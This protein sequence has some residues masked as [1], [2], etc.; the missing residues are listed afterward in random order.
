MKHRLVWLLLLCGT[1]CGNLIL[2]DRPATA[3]SATDYTLYGLALDSLFAEDSLL[4]VRDSVVA[5]RIC[6]KRENADSESEKVLALYDFDTDSD[7]VSLALDPLRLRSETR[8]VIVSE[9][10]LWRAVRPEPLWNG[11]HTA[12]PNAS[13]FVSISAIQ[14]APDSTEAV[15]HLESGCGSFCGCVEGTVWLQ[16]RGGVWRVRDAGCNGVP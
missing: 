3:L 9:A 11:F 13:Q 16:Q 6:H 15:V 12:F 8:L 5:P 14:Y 2:E 7:S 4:V 1:G 10:A